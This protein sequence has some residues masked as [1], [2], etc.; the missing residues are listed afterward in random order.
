MTELSGRAPGADFSLSGRVAIITGGAG[1]LGVRHTEAVAAAGGIPILCRHPGGRGRRAGRRRG[2]GLRRSSDGDRLDITSAQSVAM[3]LQTVRETFARVNV[4]VNKAA[5]TSK[6]EGTGRAF[7]QL[8]QFSLD[9]WNADVAV[10]LTGAFG[11]PQ[12]W[13]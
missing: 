3:L 5:N 12:A 4:L 2:Q 8:A 9:Q 13:A 1:M 10:G 7:S 6:V 11:H